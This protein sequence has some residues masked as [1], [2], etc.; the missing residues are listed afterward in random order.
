MH[1]F[2]ACLVLSTLAGAVQSS[3]QATLKPI[4]LAA[5]RDADST[6]ST[7]DAANALPKGTKVMIAAEPVK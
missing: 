4:D 6:M 1:K 7:R 2:L 3:A 5:G